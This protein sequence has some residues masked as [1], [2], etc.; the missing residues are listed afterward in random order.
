MKRY[1]V[2]GSLNMGMVTRVDHF[3]VPGETIR[4]LS[5]TIFPGGKGTN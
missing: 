2:V 4:G 3:P 1:C 5:F